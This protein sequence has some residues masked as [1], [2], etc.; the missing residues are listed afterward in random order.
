[1]APDPSPADFPTDDLVVPQ[2]VI[3]T[4]SDGMP[5]HGQ[6][7][8]PPGSAPGKKHP[9]L[10]FMHQGFEN[11]QAGADQGDKLLVEDEELLQVDLFLSAEESG[12]G[13]ASGAGL[14]GIDEEAL[15]G[16]LVAEFLFGGGGGH[17]LVDL[18]AAVSILEDKIGHGYCP[19]STN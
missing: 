8:L 10:V 16:V 6:L 7:F 15:L 3:Y 14:D 17:L 13:D 1:M 9:A 19:A 11:G 2:Q 12:S 5:V 4:A 18:A